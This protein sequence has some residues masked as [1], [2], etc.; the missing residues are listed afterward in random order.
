MSP[1]TL[2]CDV[3]LLEATRRFG[4]HSELHQHEGCTLMEIGAWN[5]GEE[6]Q[7]IGASSGRSRSSVWKLPSDERADVYL[8]EFW[9]VS[10]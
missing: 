1:S 7:A 6:S 5:A 2:P 10:S 9:R 8:C 3:L 4:G